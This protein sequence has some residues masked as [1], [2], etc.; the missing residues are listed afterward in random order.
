MSERTA[1]RRTVLK[2][3]GASLAGVALS[4]LVSSTAAAAEWTAVE[5][6]TGNTLHDV[7]YTSAGATAVAG[8]GIVLERTAKGWRKALQGGP[9]GNG[10]DLYGADVTD[11]GK[12]L[13]FVGA[14]LLQLRERRDR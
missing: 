11:D 13:W 6:P 2:A 14:R 7:V 5:S 1:T 12:R 3:T 10:N 9:T 4:G 8:G